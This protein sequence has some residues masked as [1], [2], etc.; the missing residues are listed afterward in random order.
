MD[1]AHALDHQIKVRKSKP[2]KKEEEKKKKK[3]KKKRIK[4]T[5]ERVTGSN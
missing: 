4:Q 2:D 1:L 5:E 3:K